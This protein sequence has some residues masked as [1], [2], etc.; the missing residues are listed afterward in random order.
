MGIT[1]DQ[2]KQ[3]LGQTFA[4]LGVNDKGLLTATQR[5]ARLSDI[6][7][8]RSAVYLPCVYDTASGRPEH[9]VGSTTI[10]VLV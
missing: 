4:E 7:Q 9:G 1:V 2:G 10:G 8:C 6:M 5:Q 3:S